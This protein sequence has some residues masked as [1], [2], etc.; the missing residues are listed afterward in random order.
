MAIFSAGG[1]LVSFLQGARRTCLFLSSCFLSCQPPL[2]YGSILLRSAKPGFSV[3]VCVCMS[4]GSD[5]HSKLYTV[6]QHLGEVVL[7]SP[8]R[9]LLLFIVLGFVFPNKSRTWDF[10]LFVCFILFFRLFDTEL[11]G[12]KQIKTEQK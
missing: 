8:Y 4:V 12:M 10:F 2:R 9:S 5:H 3:L 7:L 6:Y 1:T 11:G